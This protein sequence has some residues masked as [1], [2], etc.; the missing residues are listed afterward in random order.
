M[1]A[2]LIKV[3]VKIFSLVFIIFAS[4]NS[5]A[6]SPSIFGNDVSNREI[7]GD[8]EKYLLFD[9]ETKERINFYQKGRAIKEIKPE[10]SGSDLEGSFR[11]MVVDQ[12]PD[13]YKIRQK[14]KM[15]YNAAIIGQDE[16][17]MQLYKD[18]VKAEPNNQYAKFS[19]AV[20]YQKLGQFSKAKNIYHELLQKNPENSE[21]IIGNLLSII[22]D[23]SPKEATYLLSRLARQNPHASEVFAKLALAYEKVKDYDNAVKSLKE[24][25][26]VKPDVIEYKYNLAVIYDKSSDFGNALNLYDDIVKSNIAA[27]SSIPVAQIRDRIEYIKNIL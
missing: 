20:I 26:R 16:V 12:N 1:S 10:D 8:I 24:A 9:E 11:I 2:N 3:L 27:N 17:A 25:I 21:E 4:Q 14:E 6:A 7:I 19:L 22:V 13:A 23:E 18:V 5:L 15:A